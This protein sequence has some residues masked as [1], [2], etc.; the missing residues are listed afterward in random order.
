[1]PREKIQNNKKLIAAVAV[2]TAF[3]IVLSTAYAWNSMTQQRIN[4][5]T[6]KS[7]PSANLHDDFAGGPEKDVYVENNGNQSLLVRVQ[8]TELL[9]KSGEV[10]PEGA[11]DN[12][13]A[14]GW[15]VHT[16][17]DGDCT[18]C[19]FAAHEYFSWSMDGHKF[20]MPA[21]ESALGDPD[22]QIE[23]LAVGDM[24][25][26]IDYESL[27]RGAFA[28]NPTALAYMDEYMSGDDTNA[29]LLQEEILA[30]DI[31]VPHDVRQ[32]DGQPEEELARNLN[33]VRLTLIPT[34]IITMADWA[35]G[36]TY[37]EA[38]AVGS[39]WVMDT[40]GWCYW[41]NALAPRRAT[42]QLLSSVP[43]E[44]ILPGDDIIYRINVT[45]N[46]TTF[47]ENDLGDFFWQTEMEGAI[48]QDG[49]LLMLLASGGY[50][51]GADGA[52]YKDSGGGYYQKAEKTNDSYAELTLSDKLHAGD[53]G[54][55]GNADDILYQERHFYHIGNGVYIEVSGTDSTEPVSETVTYYFAGVEK[56]IENQTENPDHPYYTIGEYDDTLLENKANAAFPLQLTVGEHFD[57]ITA[58]DGEGNVYID[59]IQVDG[60][61]YEMQE[62][63]KDEGGDLY[64]PL[65]GDGKIGVGANGILGSGM[66]S[67][68]GGSDGG[69]FLLPKPSGQGTEERPFEIR[70]RA[71]MDWV[72]AQTIMGNFTASTYLAIADDV[73]VIDMGE[74]L[75][76]PIG[77]TTS[78]P[79]RANFDGKGKTITNLKVEKSV[80]LSG[81][82][83][84]IYLTGKV[85][86]INLTNVSITSSGGS[87]GMLAGRSS[88]TISNCTV[89]GAIE[90]SNVNVGGVVGFNRLSGTVTNCHNLGGTVESTYAVTES[91]VGGVVGYS[92]DTSLTADCSNA[93]T[94]KSAGGY[95]GG[96]V[97]YALATTGIAN[98]TNTGNITG[99]NINIG[100]I[101]G[102]GEGTITDCENFGNVT[103]TLNNVGGIAGRNTGTVTACKNSGNITG[104]NP[105]LGGIVGSTSGNITNSHNLSGT[106]ESTNTAA[107]SYVGGVAGYISGA[108]EIKDC[109]NAAT[110]KTAGGT[111]GGIVGGTP[112][113]D[114]PIYHIIDCTNTGSVT[115]ASTDV[116]GIAGSKLGGTITGCENSGKVTGTANRVGGIVGLTGGS[117]V[118][119]DCENSGEVTGT[120]PVGGIVG[121]HSAN[122]TVT[123]TINT[124]KVS[125]TSTVGGIVGYSA[126]IVTACENKGEVTST[127]SSVGGIVGQSIAGGS[128]E[129][130]GNS[131]EVSGDYQMI[132]GVVGNNAGTITACYNTAAITGTGTNM[133]EGVIANNVGGIAG[134]N[135]GT[136]QTSY[137]TG[138]I[139]GVYNNIGGVVGNHLSG[140]VTN[141]YAWGDIY[142]TNGTAGGV[143]GA[144]RIGASVSYVYHADGFV[145]GRD[146]GVGGAVGLNSG[147]LSWAVALS[148]RVIKNEG[149]VTSLGIGRV[150]GVNQGTV[151]DAH[152]NQSMVVTEEGTSYVTGTARAMRPVQ[153]WWE[154]TSA[155]DFTSTWTYDSFL[156]LPVLTGVSQHGTESDPYLISTE[157]QLRAMSNLVNTVDNI[158]LGKYFLQTADI[159]LG[160]YATPWTAIGINSTTKCFKG[161]YDGGGYAIGRMYIDNPTSDKQGLFGLVRGGTVKNI[162]MTL[163]IIMNENGQN[164]VG[165]I[166]GRIEEGAVVMNCTVFAAIITSGNNIG[167]IVGNIYSTST[168]ENCSFS[169][170][171]GGVNNIGGIVGRSGDAGTV[172]S[173]CTNTGEATGTTNVGGIAG[174]NNGTVRGCTNTGTPAA[175]VGGGNLE[176]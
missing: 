55:P 139:T 59:K 137:S 19:G 82:F 123:T 126:G 145:S 132:G 78:T 44:N 144:I 127:G 51:I 171:V 92:S 22:E 61:V 163:G 101:V 99:A 112:T 85:T 94:V 4:L 46:A 21:A 103:G 118:I 7:A 45:L 60:S 34:Q 136:V 89:S 74:E 49:M 140:T 71:D 30:L 100:G 166:A 102:L 159:D 152:A 70:T 142:S 83:G 96:V 67:E 25:E 2:L 108:I 109:T 73:D 90:G 149:T 175:Q 16:P 48:T 37:G 29:G 157:A 120:G 58:V 98:C 26:I 93:A 12:A 11:V 146:Y 43:H 6:T 72:S 111:V 80:A 41:A 50:T 57:I 62:L 31:V 64:I 42:G 8:L 141:C 155:F 105:S 68:G 97:G 129:S 165:A 104:A 88:G 113:T 131:G 17:A 124:G 153:T 158:T 87:I 23:P 162:N 150:V 3:L 154:N 75:F 143:V 95:V 84:D 138:D 130:C 5:L 77:D 52:L 122:C 40:D 91:R 167:G 161:V 135:A 121:T 134:H 174:L 32:Y 170:S 116:G 65:D 110:V 86:G 14:A 38:Y 76:T 39:F 117:A 18:N 176:Q 125:A 133:A 119:S 13:F 156:E 56:I 115:G 27:L 69:V 147:T 10:L 1:M 173:N 63:Q 33:E 151:S 54:L 81:L 66:D 36:D 114:Y 164:E 107:A 106:V 53:D 20:Y 160:A 28:E 169:G 168:V 15:H 128:V 24:D 9:I 148:N 172:I 35:G 47:G 79:F